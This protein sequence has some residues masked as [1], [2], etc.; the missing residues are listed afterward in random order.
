MPL[1]CLRS[2]GLTNEEGYQLVMPAAPSTTKVPN[3][4][5]I[6][7]SHWQRLS[8]KMCPG[9]MLRC[10]YR[11][12]GASG[13]SLAAH[14]VP[15]KP[16]VHT[17]IYGTH[18]WGQLHRGGSHDGSCPHPSA[19][20]LRKEAV[21]FFHGRSPHYIQT[22]HCQRRGRGCGPVALHTLYKN[23]CGIS[24]NTSATSFQ[25]RGLRHT[26]PRDIPDDCRKPSRGCTDRP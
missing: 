5:P 9:S 15:S 24:D 25:R 8:T 3:P 23:H 21:M 26:P 12:G 16:L 14:A 2:S 1:K 22:A 10:R 4:H 11:V 18:D 19:H 7:S 17:W 20:V 13:F 6:D